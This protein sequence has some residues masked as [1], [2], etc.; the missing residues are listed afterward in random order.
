MEV[1]EQFICGKHSDEECEDG[2]V[3]T[4][5]FVVVIDGSTS[6]TPLRVNPG[7]SNGQFCMKTI[8]RVVSLMPASCALD[9]FCKLA[10]EAVHKC[11]PQEDGPYRSNPRQRLCA[12]AIVYSRQ[13]NEVWM[14]GDCQALVVSPTE[15]SSGLTLF[16]NPKPYEKVVAEERSRLWP[17]MLLRHPDMVK[18]DR[19]VHDYARDA[20]LPTLVKSMNEE[21]ISYA[22][23]DG[24]PIYRPGIKV[25]DLNAFPQ[26]EC[27]VLASDGY[28]T[29][30][31]TLEKT[32]RALRTIMSQD[33]FCIGI[34]QA[35][36]GLMTGNQSFDDRSYV[37]FRP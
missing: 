15:G 34:N 25:I 10:T 13:R 21:N 14:V 27:I 6:K 11:Y 28:P 33:P 30:C 31:S 36:K 2:I 3:V 32:E 9:D 12:S 18:G 37:R 8:A 17:T 4:P 1:I 5:H 19:I 29:L 22:V 7:M 26:A 35:T 20:V 24:F 16:T 23:I